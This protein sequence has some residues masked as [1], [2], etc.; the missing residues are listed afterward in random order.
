MADVVPHEETFRQLREHL[1]ILR[2]PPA[3]QREWAS[4]HY[5][6]IDELMLSFFDMFPGFMPRLRQAGLVPPAFEAVLKR[7]EQHFQSMRAATKV[8]DPL[9]VEW[10]LVATAPEWQRVR[11][12]ASEALDLLPLREDENADAE[13]DQPMR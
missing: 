13:G 9:W 8:G 4:E 3:R 12:L 7:L 2:A 5:F 10:E 11:E 1:E 6:F